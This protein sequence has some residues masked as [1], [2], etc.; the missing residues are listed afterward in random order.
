MDPLAITSSFLV[1]WFVQ[2]FSIASQEAFKELGKATGKGIVAATR[3]LASVIYDKLRGSSSQAE[4]QIADQIEKKQIS[5]DQLS[6][7][8]NQLS[9]NNIEFANSLNFQM[10]IIRNALLSTLD[11]RFTAR[12]LNEVYFPLG[13]DADKL[14][15][16]GTPHKAKAEEIIKYMETRNRLHDLIQKIVEINP[17]VA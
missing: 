1:I 15:A 3:N 16:I 7:T 2:N 10:Q 8:I 4:Q 5:E 12:D 6:L 11:S 13:L 14:A 9:Q 17:T